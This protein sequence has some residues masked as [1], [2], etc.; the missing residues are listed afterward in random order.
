[1]EASFYE[2][3]ENSKVRC[4]LCPN[5]CVIAKGKRGIC[6]I[7]TNRNGN[8]YADAYGRVVSLAIDPVEKKPL[9]HFY[10]S[11]SILSTGPNG[12]NFRCGFCQNSEISQK[13]VPTQ[14]VSP[15]NLADLASSN[16][17]IGVAY[18][19]TEPFIWFEY[20]RDTGRVIHNRGMVNVMVTNGYVN[21]EPLSELLPLI[22]AMNIDIKSMRPDFYTKVCGGKLEDVLRTVKISSDFCHIEITNLIIPGYNDTDEDFE[23]LVDWIYSINPSMP[24]HFSRYFPRYR[25]TEP[26]TP[27][28]TLRHAFEIAKLKLKYV[29]VG[30]VSLKDTSDTHCTKCGNILVTR[31]YYQVNICGIK[32][33]TC[34]SCGSPVEFVGI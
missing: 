12:C 29:Y 30:N 24:L 22:D 6:R 31:S 16:G 2:S 34:S 21:E 28:A 33:G 5:Y 23:K 4:V 14:Y 8:L 18:T 25:F 11:K 27:V 19:Y 26:E 10:P 32:N 13:E 20:I 9:Y 17:S 7:R 1:M 3:L 15:E